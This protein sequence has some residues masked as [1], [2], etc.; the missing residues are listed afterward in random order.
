M[1]VVILSPHFPPNHINYARAVKRCGDTALGIG[2]SPTISDELRQTLD[3][4]VYVPDMMN[5]DDMVRT[6]GYLTSKY[7]KLDRLDSQNEWWLGIESHLR[8]DFNIYGQKPEQTDV[9]RSKLGMKEVAR[10][11]NLPVARGCEVESLAQLR[12]FIDEVGYPIVVKPVVGVGASATYAIHDDEELS[13]CF[14]YIHGRYICEEFIKGDT[15]TFDGFVDR[16]GQILFHTSHEYNAS[17]MD[18]VND[19]RSMFYFNR[20]KVDPVLEDLGRRCV[21]AFKVRERFFHIEWFRTKNRT[22]TEEPKY[23]FLEINVRPPGLYT[24]DMMNYSAD[25]SLYDM[26]AASFHDQRIYDDDEVVVKYSVGFAGRRINEHFK[27]S[28]EEIMADFSDSVVMSEPVPG[29]YADAMGE[30]FYLV[31]HKDE[32]RVLDII[33]FIIEVE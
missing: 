8:L 31:R 10:S 9:N 11:A 22:A 23:C 25:I 5:Y 7:G 2:D 32:Q 19:A 28:H 12:A 15:V 4:Y 30:F 16:H 3:E 24:I 13:H 33:K 18:C 21:E 1:N 20:I 17:V 6:L 14:E 27:H 29:A 26:W